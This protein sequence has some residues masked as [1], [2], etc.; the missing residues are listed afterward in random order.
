MDDGAF[1]TC[2][3]K[4][5]RRLVNQIIVSIQNFWKFYGESIREKKRKKVDGVLFRKSRLMEID[6]Y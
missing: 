5:F 4:V 2:M 6:L 1:F 3:G